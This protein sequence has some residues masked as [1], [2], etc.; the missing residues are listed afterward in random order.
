MWFFYLF[1]LQFKSWFRDLGLFDLDFWPD[2]FDLLIFDFLNLY[3]LPDLHD[4]HGF[5]SLIFC[6]V[7]TL[8]PHRFLEAM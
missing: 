1:I 8:S 5:P 2:L 7:A 3:D 6:L 4:L